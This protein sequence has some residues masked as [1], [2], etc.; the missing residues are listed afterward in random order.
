MKQL[1]TIFILITFQFVMNGQAQT[2]SG[3]LTDKN[4]GENL[5]YASISLLDTGGK[6]AQGT[7]TGA[8]GRFSLGPVKV[9][10]Y[11][12]EC[13]MMSYQTMTQQIT[14]KGRQQLAL[15][16]IRLSLG[17]QALAEVAVTGTKPALTLLPDKKVFEVGK[18]I[19][20]QNGSVS[21]VLNGIPSVNVSPQGQVTLRGNAGVTVLIN[22]RRSGLAQGSALEQLQAA[23]VERIE[24]ISSPSARY[25]A[26]GSAGIIN[27]VLKK[28][29]K[30]GFNGQVQLMAGSPNDIRV[31]P[32]LN[33]KSDRFNF[34]ATLGMRKSDYHGLYASDQQTS[35]TNLTMRQTEKRHDDGK[36]LYAGMDYQLSEKQSMTAA[37]LWNGTHDHDKEWLHYAYHTLQL[38]ST[39]KR[40]GES[41]ERRNYHQM[42]YNYTRTFNQPKQ[43]WTIDLQYD[44]WNSQKDWQL[45]T[46]KDFPTPESYPGLRTR[47]DDTNHDFL[48]Q[49]DWV[50][51][52]GKELQLEAGIKTENRSVNYSFLA[53]QQNG[54]NYQPYQGM[55]NDLHYQESIRGA[56]GQL[57]SKSGKWTYLGGLRAEATRVD[58]NIDNRKHYTWFF[59]TAH[60]NYAV[61]DQLT[62]QAHYSTRI[63]RPSL[64]SLSPYAELTD[65]SSRYIGNPDQ[66][67]SYTHIFELGLLRKDANLTINPTLFYQNILRPFA[68]YTSRDAAGV[69]ITM[70]VNLAAEHRSGAELNLLWNPITAIQLNADFNIYRFSQSGYYQGF[71]FAY[72]GSSSGGR[73]TAQIKLPAAIGLQARYY[74]NGPSSTAQSRTR[75]MHWA[76]FGLNKKVLKDKLALTADVT[77]AFDSRRYRTT[78]TGSDYTVVTL[79]RFNGARYR[80]SLTY[81]IG[82]DGQAR[83]A[84][85]GNRN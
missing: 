12:L 36:M 23:Q 62:L 29:R 25:D 57:S 55:Q 22:G 17:A 44:W 54:E 69:L 49:S 79:N 19:L 73:L 21:E 34:F 80:L 74:Y 3:K 6:L 82:G 4:T 30:A 83:Q 66:N 50:Q 52:L 16:T 60:L 68:D 8:D 20:S 51:P 81:K 27:I 53:T 31:N 58:V 26:T 38:D 18:D 46:T 24:V 61:D 41:W 14:L 76:D 2:V 78:I 67:P 35:Q 71:N 72:T 85:A 63:S 10:T 43:K 28:N 37:Y 9:G 56:Y 5:P 7:M 32:S 70:P 77:N 75:A 48:L 47:T 64:Y 84:R 45:A 40:S 33:Y 42:E 65:L 1:L 15:G 11:T 13:R 59:P 39:L